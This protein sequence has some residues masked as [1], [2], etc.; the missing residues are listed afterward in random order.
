[1]KYILQHLGLGDHIMCNGLVRYYSKLNDSVHLFCKHNNV[2]DVEYMFRDDS[3]IHIIP[4]S[5]DDDAWQKIN[6]D[7]NIKQ[8][9]VVVGHG[10]TPEKN[11][12]DVYHYLN[13]GKRI[14]RTFYEMAEVPF[15][16]KVTD[17]FF[18][19]NYEN[20]KQLIFQL[21][22]NNSPYIFIHDDPSRGY[23]M[24]MNKVRKD[25]YI[26]RP[27]QGFNLLDYIGILENAEEIHVMESSFQV[28]IDSQVFKKPRLF[29]HRYIRNYEDFMLPEQTNNYTMVY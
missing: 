13:Q 22:P 11:I 28:L 25:L 4:V 1:M 23:H 9:L 18:Q 17:F 3:K 24:D 12:Q 26:I 21:N 6:S 29:L 14:D 5:S 10:G 15:E 8:N 20:E 2:A 7:I 27:V 19:R 16:K